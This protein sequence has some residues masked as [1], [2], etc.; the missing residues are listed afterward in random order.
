[1]KQSEKVRVAVLYGG[2][3]AEHEVSLRSAANVIQNLDQ[4]RY[5]VIPLGIDK[6]GNWFLGDEVY[7][8][9]L[10]NKKIP[11]LLHEMNAWFTP[12]WVGT[13]AEAGKPKDL[14]VSTPGPL[15]DVVF[16]VVHGTLC[17]DG[18]LQG[19]L[20]LSGL[21]Y[22]G[23]GVLSSAMGM[24][25]D[26]SKRIAM[27]AGVKVAPYLA[28]KFEQWQQNPQRQIK[29]IADQLTHPIFV[30]PANAGSSVGITRVKSAEHLEAAIQEA[31]RFDTKIVL[32]KALNIVELEVA[33]LEAL[34]PDAEPIVSVVGEVRPTGKHEFYSYDAKYTDEDGADLLIPAPI[35]PELQEKARI[36]AKELFLALECEGLARV[37][38]FLNKDDQ[39]IYFN[40]VNTLPGFT[41]IS[42]YPKLMGA[43]GVSY[44]ALLTHLI[45]LAFKR[46][47][48]KRQLVRTYSGN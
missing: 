3:S 32:E 12:E 17:E 5:E 18:T 21:P 47:K 19:L 25:K 7:L 28:I 14:V 11:K 43:S 15:F 48:N 29:R 20:E 35:A 10:Q 40:E 44:Q 24:D 39:E 41:Q 37:D 45:E 26:I 42:M 1:M 2:R 4:S 13:P 36:V 34:E 27:A 16:P 23:S 30:K 38:L 33:V 46:H 22:V 31:F 9:S 6:Q 8:K